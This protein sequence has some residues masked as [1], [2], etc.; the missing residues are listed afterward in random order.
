MKLNTSPTKPKQD[1]AG[2]SDL[3]KS[4]RGAG[5]GDTGGSI[6]GIRAQRA[7]GTPE[8]PDE[9]LENARAIGAA[10]TEDDVKAFMAE[11]RVTPP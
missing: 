3:L 9:A 11:G 5:E 8:P 10:V 7:P 4:N 1:D 2:F 6:R